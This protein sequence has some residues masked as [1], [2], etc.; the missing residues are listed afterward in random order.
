M[1]CAI[2]ARYSS[3]L[4][5]ERSIVDQLELCRDYARNQQM[6]VVAEHAD[7]A[8]SGASMVCLSGLAVLLREAEDR[9]FDAVLIESFERIGRDQG[10]LLN[11]DKQ[12]R[13]L[14]IPIIEV[15]G[16]VLTRQSAGLKAIIAESYLADLADKTR[17]GQQGRVR[18]GAIPGGRSYGYDLVPGDE[19]GRRTVN[20][21]QA[22]IILRIFREYAEGRS[23]LAIAADLNREGIPSPR[24]GKWNQSAIN[25]SRKRGNGVLWNELY[26]GTIVYNRQSFRKHPRTGKR[27]ARPNPPHL[28]QRQKAP[29]L[30]IVPQDLWDQA[31][32]QRRNIS[33][34]VPGH[35]PRAKHLL[36]GLMKCGLC[37]ESYILASRHYLGC[38]GYR[39]KRTCS[40]NR[41]ISMHEVE[42]RVLTALQRHLLAPEVVAAGVQA[43]R[44][45]RQR[46]ARNRARNEGV[47]KREL[48]ELDR[49]IS[50]WVQAIG[51]GVVEAKAIKAELNAACARRDEIDAMLRA[52]PREDAAVLHPQA[53]ERYRQRVAD[54]HAALKLGDTAG[55]EA[56]ALVRGM[57]EAI[58]IRP[59]REKM[60]LTVVG[61]LAAFLH[62]EQDGNL[63]TTPLVAGVGFEPT[64]F[65][66]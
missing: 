35:R 41:T 47:L 37:G 15:H 29:E 20:E 12:L 34:K 1:R 22:A 28:W 8:I 65:R 25:G 13:Y 33:S 18:A 59:G 27:Q 24:G 7:S 66:L 40:N 64:T 38:S 11:V 49:K 48:G 43:Y 53:A 19:R 17:R 42:D 26:I 56:V 10:D 31:H 58:E 51:D 54:V 6:V 45:E 9:R 21:R 55:R 50:R 16:G 61:D 52:L 39:N 63:S 3:P 32:A 4:Q 44:E 5:S 2:Y 57:I 14:G 36:S 60:E 30:R 62:R 23:P 46:L